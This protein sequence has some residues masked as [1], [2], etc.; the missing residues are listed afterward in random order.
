MTQENTKE[1]KFEIVYK[2]FVE[3][4]EDVMDTPY[5]GERKCYERVLE[6]FKQIYNEHYKIV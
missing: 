2:Q 6:K 4:L 3:Y 1:E 5:K